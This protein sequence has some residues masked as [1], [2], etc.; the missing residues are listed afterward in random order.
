MNL[1]IVSTFL[2]VFLL[3]KPW[4]AQAQQEARYDVVIYGGT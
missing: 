2:F 4:H 3:L 1:K